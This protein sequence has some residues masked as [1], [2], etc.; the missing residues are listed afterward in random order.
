MGHLSVVKNR[1]GL[2]RIAMVVS[3]ASVFISTDALCQTRDVL[4]S[5]ATKPVDLSWYQWAINTNESL[6]YRYFLSGANGEAFLAFRIELA[7][8]IDGGLI[9]VSEFDRL[10]HEALSQAEAADFATPVLPFDC[11]AQQKAKKICP[12]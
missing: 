2:R 7:S 10:T 1:S 3:I 11:D 12:W 5:P 9:S 8:K 4:P 6:T